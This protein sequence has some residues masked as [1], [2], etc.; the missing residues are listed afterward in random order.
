MD[1]MLLPRA[2]RLWKNKA[3]FFRPFRAAAEDVATGKSIT[4]LFDPSTSQEECLDDEEID[5][6]DLNAAL[7]VLIQVFPDVETHVFREMLCNVSVESRVAIVTEQVLRKTAKSNS[8]KARRL[9]RWGESRNK[10]APMQRP[11][12]REIVPVEETFRGQKYHFAVKQL[13]YQE[14]RGLSHS[15][16]RGVM[17]EHNGSYTRS[18]PTL[19]QLASRTWRFSLSSFWAKRPPA[20]Q[21]TDHPALTWQNDDSPSDEATPAVKR[22]GSEQLDRELYHL[23][24]H[25][26][27]E[28]QRRKQLIVDQTL[29]LQINE[30]AA[31]EA[32]STFDC[33]CCYSAVAFEQI[34]A[35]N[36]GCHYLCFDCIRRTT[37]EALYGQGWARSADLERTTL[38]CFAPA[39]QECQGSI[40]AVLVQR[41]LHEDMDNADIWPEFQRRAASEILIKS[42]VLLQRCPFCTYAEVDETPP[43]R[44]RNAKQVARHIAHRSSPAVQTSTLLLLT[45]LICL[46]SPAL[47]LVSVLFLL[48]IVIPPFAQTVNASWTRVYKRRRGLKFE[49]QDDSCGRTS[50]TRCL[51]AWQDPHICFESEKTSLRTAMEASATAAVKRTCPRCMLSF[52]KS[53]GCNKLV[54]NCG[55]TM[56]YVCRAEI[57]SKEGYSHFCQ[58]FRPNGGRCVECERCDLYGNEDEELAIRRAAEAEEREWRDKERVKGARAGG[59]DEVQAAKRMVDTIVEQGRR[60]RWYEQWSDAVVDAIAASEG[61]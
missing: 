48:L 52:V 36:D 37:R 25:P 54:C 57:T 15:T 35:C 21:E 5:L 32:K 26:V 30:E 39:I 28:R 59:E 42:R 55:Y 7:R 12:R 38:R 33:E 41:A 18:R 3:D 22:T 24:V 31:V 20:G 47:L 27:L 43:P 8:G 61:E 58:H 45:I 53:S 9:L 4:T 19:Q 6:A 10:T 56:C 17:A 29:A 23:L 44:L 51:A 34:A 16:I 1:S 13:L 50:C 60:G 49:C 40:P 14:F 2:S 46:A 11:F